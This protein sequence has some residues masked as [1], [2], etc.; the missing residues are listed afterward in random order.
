MSAK[1]SLHPPH[2]EQVTSAVTTQMH[3]TRRLACLCREDAALRMCHVPPQV[4]QDASRSPSKL[5][6]PSQGKGIQVCA[7]QLRVVIQHLLKVGDV[8]VVI[9]TV[10]VEAAS[11]LVIHAP[12]C[13]LLQSELHYVQC[14]TYTSQC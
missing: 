14:L 13:H 7:D 10:S 12:C 6:I 4:V 8:P 11:H 2:S 3:A 9:H 1:C 5:L